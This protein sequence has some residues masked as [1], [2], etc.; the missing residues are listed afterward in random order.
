MAGKRPKKRSAKRRSSKKKQHPRGGSGS[1][2]LRNIVVA[3]LLA[4]G[5]VA[6]LYYFGSFETRAKM[7]SL[8]LKWTQPLRIHPS[9]PAP[10]AAWL[11]ALHD[12]MPTST[13]FTVEGGELGRDPDSPF[14]AGIPRAEDPVQLARWSDNVRIL[15]DGSGRSV[16]IALR[17]DALTSGAGTAVALP[18]EIDLDHAAWQQMLHRFTLRYPKRFEDVWIYL[19]PIGGSAASS[20]PSAHYAIVFDITGIG[21]LRALALRIPSDAEG[22]RLGDYITS[23]SKIEQSTG[24]RFLPELDFSLRGALSGHVSPRLW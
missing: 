19:G 16:C 18:E 6:G 22:R 23:I 9:T 13:G 10:V 7:E 21:G 1:H 24:L 15:R 3:L 4:G 20:R 8:A 17:L 11:D 14:I 5:L 2:W 12:S